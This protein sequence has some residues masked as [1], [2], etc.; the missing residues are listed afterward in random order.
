MENNPKWHG[1]GPVPGAIG[2]GVEGASVMAAN[3][4]LEFKMGSATRAAFGEALLELGRKEKR[5]VVCDA[6]LS[7][8]TMTH[9]FGQEFP[10]RFFT[11]GIAE[12][13]M[14]A[15]GA[16]LASAGKIAFVSS[17]SC[18]L[19]NKGFEQLRV[20]V[21]Y[22][23]I[24]SFVAVGTHSGI[25]IG[26]DGPSQMSVEDLALACALPGFAVI[27]PADEIAMKAL[28][29]KAAYH[30]GPVFVRAGRPKAPIVHAEGTEFSIGGSVQLRDGSDVTIISHGLLVAESLKA[31]ESLGAEGISCR[32]IDMYSIKPLDRDAI[33]RAAAETGALVVA[34]EHLVDSGLG[35][36]VAQVVAETQAG[37]HGV[38]RHPGHLR[39][40][41]HAARPAGE[42]R[43]RGGEHRRG[44][45]QGR[46]TQAGTLTR[47]MPGPRHPLAHLLAAVI[48][49]QEQGGARVARLLHDEV[50]QILTAV[51]LQ[52]DLMRMDLEAECPEIASRVVES[53]KILEQA[54]DQVR[55]LSYE[56]HPGIVERAGLQAAL[57]RLAG[58]YRKTPN[59]TV[60]LMFDS[61]V[62]VPAEAAAAMYKIAECALENSVKHS[63][64]RLI[65]ILVRPGRGGV[66]LEV[67]DDGSGFDVGQATGNPAGLGLLL[68]NCYADQGSLELE[69]ASTPGEGTIVKAR[70]RNTGHR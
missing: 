8:S 68:M 38:R 45:P 58:R 42:I 34:E 20:T 41:R 15:V 11:C 19:L 55:S 21:A 7:K 29:P 37:D 61:S 47:S 51:G 69:I 60:R 44:G 30:G 63:Q 9:D 62:R 22:P 6:D 3:T 57:D 14:V 24:E 52:M 12:A 33:G 56:L 39:R 23:Q 54:V 27:A 35:V 66:V 40:I 59:I 50:G 26:E 10:E 49:A 32:V 53:Q 25:S 64:C 31:A 28:I 65:E 4:N 1:V 5:V 13:N 67:K 43:P 2:N 46:G 48:N 70:C 16:G 36:R 18:F 17:F